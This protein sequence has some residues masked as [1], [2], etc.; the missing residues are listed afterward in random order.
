MKPLVALALLAFA[1]E[2]LA[3]GLQTHVFL[4][5]QA[6]PQAAL[7]SESVLVLAGAC[8]PDL[9]LAGQAI[10]TPAFGRSHRWSTLR[11][12]AAAPRDER[13]RSLA[14]GYA[15]HLLADVVAHN[16][17][18]PDHE[19]RIARIPHFTHA[20]SEWAMDQHIR[21]RIAVQPAEL[22][23][24]HRKTLVD[25][26][27]RHFRCGEALATRG[28]S[29][30]TAAEG[31]L[32]GSRLPALC[33]RLVGAAR[34][35][36]YLRHACDSLRGLEKAL[37]GRL[38]DWVSSDPEGRACNEGANRRAGEDIARIVQAEHHT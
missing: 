36:S 35:D 28:I 4:A 10:G 16:L 19:R 33:L 25:F 21:G 8:L 17:F 32:R 29:W 12:I 34:F 23:R 14:I 5:Q 2:A 9:A 31:L 7:L 24:E 15:T 37:E 22:L 13:D 20:L 26:V 18:V 27:A 30:L 1:P 6:V 11:R 38:I 3:W